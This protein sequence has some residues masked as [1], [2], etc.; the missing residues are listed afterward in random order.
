MEGQ[1]VQP[2]GEQG[3]MLSGPNRRKVRAGSK[4]HG[5]GVPKA[6]RPLWQLG[7]AIGNKLQAGGAK[8][9]IYNLLPKEKRS[10][11]KD[12]NKERTT[13]RHQIKLNYK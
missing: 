2:F 5:R 4:G 10:V 3:V 8:L 1:L 7:H 13:T 9:F 11:H 6:T 12:T